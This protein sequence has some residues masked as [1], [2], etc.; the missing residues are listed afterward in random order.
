MA[1]V[2][3]HRIVLVSGAP[4][5][6]KTTIAQPLAEALGFALLSKDHI[7]ET[8]FDALDGKPGDLA[9]SRKIG[10]ASMELLWA[11]AARCPHVVLEANFRPKS[12]CERARIAGLEGQVVEVYCRC[13]PEEAARRYAA[14]AGTP[15]RHPAHVISTLTADNLEEF[16]RPVGIGKVIEVDTSKPVDIKALLR[17]LQE[18]WQDNGT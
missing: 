12:D 18:A 11:L 17:K 3:V 8:L 5:A 2:E 15:D 1:S 9:Y 13:P 14:R 4:G 10:G 16:D 6:G 7:K